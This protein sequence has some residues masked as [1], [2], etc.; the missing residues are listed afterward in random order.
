M[1]KRF[2]GAFKMENLNLGTGYGDFP[3]YQ[4]LYQDLVQQDYQDDTEMD[5]N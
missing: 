1:D 2:N 5:Y 4:E 3:S